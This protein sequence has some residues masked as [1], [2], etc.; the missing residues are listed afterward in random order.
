MKAQISIENKI[1]WGLAASL[2]MLL[3]V[4]VISFRSVQELSQTG[5]WVAH[6]QKVI[7]EVEAG[8]ALITDAETAQRAY[9]L[10]TNA[11]FLQDCHDAESRVGA[12]YRE[13]HD[14]TLDNPQQQAILTRLS[15]LINQR[16]ALLNQRIVLRQ[17]EGL[18]AVVRAVANQEGRNLSRSLWAEFTEL[19]D[20]E[21]RLL[22]GRQTE[23]QHYT[24]LA[25]TIV[26]VG[27]LIALAMGVTALNVLRLNLRLRKKT[28][29]KLRQ[30]E[31]L[32]RSMIENVREYG[33]FML[34]ARGYVINWNSGAQRIKGYRPE[35]IIG[36][37]FSI[38]YPEDVVKSG[39]PA[40]ELEMAKTE[41]RFMD[42]SWRIRKDGTRFWANVV[43]TPI[44]NDRKDLLG[45]VK[46]T[47][48]L[49]AQEA[50]RRELQES[51][52][53]LQSILD[54]T[55]ALVYVQDREGRYTFINRKF[56]Q[57]SGRPRAEIIGRKA[58][59]LFPTDRAEAIEREHQKVISTEQP[60]EVE[61]MVRYPDG[62]HP[63]WAIKFPLRDAAGNVYGASGISYDIAARKRIEKMHLEFRALFE[64]LPGSY[65]VLNPDLK[66]VAVSD[67][68][69]HVTM[70][71]RE[72][73]LNRG[74]FEVFP[75]NPDLPA[76][77]GVNNLRASINRVLQT[78]QTDT[79]AI[80]RYDI[81]RPDGQF[82]ER[83]WSPVNSPV[84]SPNREITYIVHR[85]EDVTGFVLRKQATAGDASA[86][87]LEQM[88]A[89]IFQSSQQVQT[90]NLQLRAANQ[91]LESF[92]YSVS[93]DLRAPL[94][95]I[96]GFVDMLKKQIG[97]REDAKSDRCLEIISNAARQMGNLI[98]D[99]LV[100]S[101]MS[102]AE[103]HYSRLAQSSLVYEARD[104]LQTEINGRAIN[105]KIAELP[106]VE[107]DP[108]MMLQVWLNLIANAVKYTRTR[109]P[110]EI[111]I[112]CL[113]GDEGEC[114]FFVR[115][116]GVGF[117][118]Q[119]SAKLFGVFQRL[120]RSDEFEGTGIGLA[121]V[122]R[123]VS[124]HGGRTW[125]EG[126]VDGGATFYFSLNKLKS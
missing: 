44:W 110:A 5:H 123:I 103:L 16:F 63:H 99:L 43:I 69:L 85:V 79:M 91:E 77:D 54:N 70:T 56:E 72:Q 19:R 104:R 28:E 94:R 116:N 52:S 68:Y 35:E 74:L 92:S 4:G 59:E 25:L 83:Y 124:R 30:S 119:Y 26:V 46:I 13:I 55:P 93:H 21:N 112:G 67:A 8:R 3:T 118:E 121:N 60:V 64:C 14:L 102:R 49:T 36:K 113:P 34:D 90:A 9:L 66:I 1:I 89:E 97:G 45:F 23:L 122:R 42:E 106:L 87:K 62:L 125:A 2:V 41:G 53:Q 80:Q 33:I 120:H 109:N 107:A 24:R 100:F 47:R 31:E 20:N 71:Q 11:V 65:L 73:L 6:T 78:A 50:A 29:E 105:W 7:S 76:A 126:K 111:E 22:A 57:I 101:R 39:F 114:I 27:T 18:D 95:H 17:R 58:R 12:W 40:R 82:E 81:R 38:F 48:D 61:E 37:H 15:G 96:S 51:R 117:D 86:Q 75:D 88:E 115:D 98:D 32:H 84:L 108:S 10:T